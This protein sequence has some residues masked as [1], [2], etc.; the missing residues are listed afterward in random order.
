MADLFDN[1]YRF[2]KDLGFGGFGRVF[3]AEEEK[4]K[5]LVAI[6][7]L[8]NKDKKRQ[9]SIVHEMQVLGKFNHPN[10]V[11]YKHY[12]IQEE[13]LYIVMEYCALGSLSAM[14]QHQKTTSTFV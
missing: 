10:I 2:V 8:N 3:L 12:F 9:D 6:K 7:Q 1:R 14:M 11:G 5:H 4:S 13:L